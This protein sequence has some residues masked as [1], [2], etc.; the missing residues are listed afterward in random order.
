MEGLGSLLALLGQ[1]TQSFT[2]VHTVALT[3]EVLPCES[4]QRP[5]LLPLT[6]GCAQGGGSTHL[7]KVVLLNTFSISV[8]EKIKN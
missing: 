6:E 5:R 2:E 1:L 4:L 3:Q 8:V 7:S